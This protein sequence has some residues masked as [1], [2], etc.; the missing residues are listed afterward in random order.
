MSTQFYKLKVSKVTQ[1]TKDCVSIS[2]QLPST[3][4]D[5]FQ[6]SAGQYLT[7]RLHI[8]GQEA[9][10][11]YSMSSSPLE[12]VLTVSVKKVKNG[13]VSTYI[14]DHVKEGQE[15]EVMPPDGR[16][17]VVPDAANF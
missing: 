4:Q 7:L 9:R 5:I 15:L 12:D 10:R 6:Y 13:L 17:S 1:E 2:F 11:A 8:K 3:L 16:F 14:N